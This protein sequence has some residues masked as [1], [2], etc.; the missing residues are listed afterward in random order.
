MG[1]GSCSTWW[2]IL[3]RGYYTRLSP[4]GRW[5]KSVRLR[6][7][8]GDP[9]A[10]CDGTGMCL[11]HSMQ[12][13]LGQIGYHGRFL[14]E[15]IRE[16]RNGGRWQLGAPIRIVLPLSLDVFPMAYFRMHVFITLAVK[17]AGV[18]CRGPC[19]STRARNGRLE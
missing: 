13:K 10:S 7:L 1:V 12:L 5:A 18:S 8:A 17:L 16:G 9:C 19:V 6:S 3:A 2:G 4:T 11:G 14:W 15:G